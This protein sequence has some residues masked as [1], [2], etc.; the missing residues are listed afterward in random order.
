VHPNDDVNQGQS[1]NSIFPSA[2]KIAAVELKRGVAG[3]PEEAGPR[4]FGQK[5]GEFKD[6]LKSGRTHLQDA[7]PITLGRS[8]RRMLRAG[9]GRPAHRD[10]GAPSS[11]RSAW[12]AMRLAPGST[13]R[14]NSARW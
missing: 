14:G 8:S 1:T 6:V 9:E 7:V 4:L 3:Q 13:R 11:A 12:A 5:G 2:I 10:G